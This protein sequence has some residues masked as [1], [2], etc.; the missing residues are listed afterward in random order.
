[1]RKNAWNC[2]HT[3]RP[4]EDF[5]LCRN[6]YKNHKYKN[7][8]QYRRNNAMFCR[9]S[10]LRRY[11]ITPEQFNVLSIKQD[12]KCAICNKSPKDG[13]LRVDHCHETNAVRGLLCIN[14]NANLGWY[15]KQLHA[16]H[17]YLNTGNDFRDC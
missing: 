16:I 13:I 4:T 3:D 14:C 10:K 15:E 12:H 6:C 17:T 1:M 8:S 2:E 9:N 5:G 11:G 7:D